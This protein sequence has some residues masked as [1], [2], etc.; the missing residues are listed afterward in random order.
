MKAK[1]EPFGQLYKMELGS[2]SPILTSNHLEKIVYLPRKQNLL[3]RSVQ[4]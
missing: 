1:F 2:Y 4:V 3:P